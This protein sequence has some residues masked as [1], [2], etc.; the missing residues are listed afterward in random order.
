MHW[1]FLGATLI[2]VRVGDGWQLLSPASTYTP[3]GMKP[4]PVEAQ[5]VLITDPKLPVWVRSVAAGPDKKKSLL[6]LVTVHG[7]P[8]TAFPACPVQILVVK[9]N[10]RSPCHGDASLFCVTPV[11]SVA[12]CTSRPRPSS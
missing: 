9:S 4:W 2:A 6:S 3:Y 7:L 5:D 10:V 1:S 8:F 11:S 12:A